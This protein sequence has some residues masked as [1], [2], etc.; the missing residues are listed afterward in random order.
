[1]KGLTCL[2]WYPRGPLIS[3]MI[4]IVQRKITLL[5]EMMQSVLNIHPMIYMDADFQTKSS[6]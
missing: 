3:F 6:G 4:S 1:M 5:G 2:C